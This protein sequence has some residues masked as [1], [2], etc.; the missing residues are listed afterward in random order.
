MTSDDLFAVLDKVPD[1][2]LRCKS[3]PN[4]GEFCYYVGVEDAFKCL[5]Q[6]MTIR[7]HLREVAEELEK[8]NRRMLD[9]VFK[10]IGSG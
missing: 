9:E 10:G 1:P 2:P 7:N 5:F 6:P 4:S 8:L 3:P